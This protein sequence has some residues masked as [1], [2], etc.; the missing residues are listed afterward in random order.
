M[1]PRQVSTSHGTP[2]TVTP[3]QGSIL[4]NNSC[5]IRPPKLEIEMKV[6][7]QAITMMSRTNKNRKG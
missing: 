3:R 1:L 6:H 4:K 5:E 7:L 2:D